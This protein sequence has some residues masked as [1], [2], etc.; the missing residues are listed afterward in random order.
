M[1]AALEAQAADSADVAM[2]SMGLHTTHRRQQ[3]GET[4]LC[5]IL[6]LLRINNVQTVLPWIL[7][8]AGYWYSVVPNPTQIS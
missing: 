2:A 6:R 5:T 8:C 4:A 7:L 3:P 1:D